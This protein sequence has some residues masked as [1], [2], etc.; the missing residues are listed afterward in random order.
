MPSGSDIAEYMELVFERIDDA[1]VLSNFYCGIQEMDDFIH[2]KL[3]GYLQRTDCEAY[4]IKHKGE[5]VAMLSLGE[6]VLCLD[7]DDKGDMRSGFIPKPSKALETQAFLMEKEFPA[8][9]IT[10]LA[11]GKDWRGK[12]I[13]EFII[14]QVENK[15]LRER[16][17]CEFVTVEAYHAE[18][19]S[20]VGFYAHCDFT[21][22]EQPMGFKNTLRMYK[23]LHP[24]HR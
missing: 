3:Q 6:D 7:E 12:G 4:A 9:E 22:A 20:A 19:Y 8:V 18:G 15:V 16:P 1:S 5:I 21:P 14:S 13:G 24:S 2:K 11:V 10:Y 17:E 23:V